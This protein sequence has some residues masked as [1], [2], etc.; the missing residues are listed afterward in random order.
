AHQRPCELSAQNAVHALR[1]EPVLVE[2]CVQPVAADVC[3]RIHAPDAFDERPSEPRGGVHLEMNPD[4]GGRR[5]FCVVDRR[6]TRIHR[7][8]IGSRATQPRGRRR[9]AKRLAPELVCGQK[10]NPHSFS[11]PAHIRRYPYAMTA[12]PAVAAPMPEPLEPAPP[13]DRA[14]FGHPRG[15]STLFFTEMWE[16]FSF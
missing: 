3:L 1:P 4:E 15:L 14:F 16:R 11:L 9:E 8:D 7:D 12:L 5:Q 2:R 13:H 10:K 6:P